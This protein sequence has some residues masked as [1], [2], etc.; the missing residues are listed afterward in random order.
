MWARS[1]ASSNQERH[2]F[3]LF[4]TGLV[5]SGTK[6]LFQS[7]P[8]EKEDCSKR[9]NNTRRNTPVAVVENR[10]IYYHRVRLVLFYGTE[11]AHGTSKYWQCC[12]ATKGVQLSREWYQPQKCLHPCPQN[13]F[14]ERNVPSRPAHRP[15]SIWP[16]WSQSVAQTS[17]WSIRAFRG[18]VRNVSSTCFATPGR[19]PWSTRDKRRHH[20]RTVWRKCAH[21]A[22]SGAHLMQA[23]FACAVRECDW[24]RLGPSRQTLQCVGAKRLETGSRCPCRWSGTI[25]PAICK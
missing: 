7:C 15:S 25:P 11:I 21:N 9:L 20:R 8:E 24:S 13:P 10:K 22:G 6:Q 4:D 23:N 19:R 3:S 12:R 2:S 5:S 14:V 18:T 17:S 16:S 1:G